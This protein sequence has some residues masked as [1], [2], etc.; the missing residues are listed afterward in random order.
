MQENITFLK[1]K[2]SLTAG[3]LKIQNLQ[4]INE[5]E[6]FWHILMNKKF[7]SYWIQIKFT[8]KFGDM[9]ANIYMEQKIQFVFFI[10]YNRTIY[11]NNYG[12]CFVFS[13]KV[14][15]QRSAHFWRSLRQ[16]YLFD[17]IHMMCIWKLIFLA[18]KII[19]IGFHRIKTFDESNAIITPTI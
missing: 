13:K 10:L 19:P 14:M 17:Q 3:Y 9:C 2:I 5:K 16:K 8:S 12:K 15:Q 6:T 7:S 4:K 11:L 1:K 18:F